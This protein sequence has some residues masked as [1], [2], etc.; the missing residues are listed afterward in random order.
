MLVLY[1]VGA[2]Y[3]VQ[4]GVDVV[5]GDPAGDHHHLDVVQQ[6]RDLLGCRFLALVLG[7]HPDLGGLLDDLLADG[8]D[9]LAHQFRGT[10]GG[11]IALGGLV[12][13]LGEELFEAL[14]GFVRHDAS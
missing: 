7:G 9:T 13:E 5:Q 8:M 6:L 11:G 4:V 14:G 1:G 2:G 3:G 10:G 12:L